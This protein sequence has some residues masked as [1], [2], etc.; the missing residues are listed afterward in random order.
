MT[1]LIALNDASKV[2]LYHSDRVFNDQEIPVIKSKIFEFVRKWVS[3]NNALKSYGNLFH[4]R[5]IALFVD[6]TMSK[7]SGC[8][9]DTSV[10]FLEALGHQMQADFFKR[11]LFTTI[12]D[13]VVET[14]SDSEFRNAYQSGIIND[15][16]LVIDNLVKT[17]SEFLTEWVKPLNDSWLKRFV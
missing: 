16:T 2:W 13:N 3:H 15:H 17:K 11:T 5:V 4:G 6:E 7:A 9:I 12:K 8:S 10:H 14:Y 1:N